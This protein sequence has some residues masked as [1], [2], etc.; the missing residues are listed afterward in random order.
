ML[1]G[2][3]VRVF[4]TVRPTWRLSGNAMFARATFDGCGPQLVQP[5]PTRPLAMRVWIALLVQ[6]DG[7]IGQNLQRG[8]VGGC[9][10]GVVEETSHPGESGVSGTLSTS[11]SR[12]R[13][14]KS[15]GGSSFASAFAT[16]LPKS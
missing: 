15:D 11:A 14:S 10:D 16:D 1:D 4:V 6:S 7:R 9:G 5:T 2:M 8:N 12:L 3:R 13:I